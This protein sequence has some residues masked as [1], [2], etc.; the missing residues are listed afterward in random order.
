MKMLKALTFR[1]VKLFFKDK[2]MF[3][4]AMITPLILLVLYVTFLGNVYKDSF[5]QG[6]PQGI[7]VPDKL[8]NGLVGGQL[9]SSLLAVCCVTVAFCSNLLSVQDKV[10]GARDDIAMTPVRGSVLAASY[11]ISTAI[12]TLLICFV[13]TA[14]AFVYLACIGWFL[15][16]ADALL[17]LF[18]VFILSM[19]GTA[20]SSV[21]S[22]FLSTQ[23][24]MSAVGSIIS[25]VY[26][27]LCGAYMPISQFGKGLQNVIAVLPGTYGTS[28]LRNHAMNGTLRELSAIGIPEEAI[29]AT[30]DVVD[31]NVYFF[32]KAVPMGIMYTI[33]VASVLILAFVYVILSRQSK[34][35]SIRKKVIK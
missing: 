8:I 32:G 26:G 15:S 9:M 10:S 6:L 25:S 21:I 4:T 16:V 30:R 34:K 23:G 29:E 24:Q 12:S 14:V 33:I 22:H 20:L 13:A 7:A 3:F 31:A 19:F 18:D 2:G 27:F 35:Q 1:N 11:Y 17:F 5:L 28:L